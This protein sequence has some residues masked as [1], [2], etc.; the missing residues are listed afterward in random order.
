MNK[1]EV[2]RALAERTGVS[3]AE[4][5]RC[6]EA[7]FGA[8][9]GIVPAVLATG[10]SVALRGFGTFEA[11]RYQPRLS[12]SPLTGVVTQLP[13]RRA[14]GFRPAAGLRARLREGG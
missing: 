1:T 12:R 13:A 3:V 11:R 4:A 14:V 7:L 8:E 6:L 10:G 9:E 2:V 5:A